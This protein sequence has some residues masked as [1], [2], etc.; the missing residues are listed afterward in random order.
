[1][2]AASL[3]TGPKVVMAPLPQPNWGGLHAV[4]EAV[5]PHVLDAGYEIRP[6]VPSSAQEIQKR[7]HRAGISAFTLEQT[8]LRRSI[9]PADHIRFLSGLVTDPRALGALAEDCGAEI[10]QA[11][12]LH[13]VQAPLAARRTGLALVWQIHSDFLPPVARRLLT[14]LATR[15]SDVI[16]VNGARVR[17][18]FPLIERL[19]ND[20]IIEFRAPI[21]SDRF[22]FTDAQRQA[23]R[24]RF[25]VGD[26]TIM[27]GTIGARSYQKGHE[28]MVALAKRLSSDDRIRSVI[29]GGEIAAQVSS[30][31]R[32]VVEPAQ[33]DGLVDSGKLAWVDAGARVLD[34]LPALDIFVL[35]SRAEGIP[36]AMLEAMASSLPVVASDVGSI[37]DVIKPDSN[38]F[39]IQPSPFDEDGFVTAV[40]RLAAD[41]A[42]RARLG[43]NGRETAQRDFSAVSVA[44]A[45]V[46]AY[47]TALAVRAAAKARS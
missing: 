41:P 46:A 4:I 27:I 33:R 32:T 29:I 18:A 7:F 31:N 14:P 47:E 11:A 2:T 1:M 6:V 12:G 3:R 5:S 16:M 44:K 20:R 42:L 17:A 22:V 38:G 45:H 40:Q 21:D 26:D 15:M 37:A 9:N 23:A 19:S 35:P 8:R 25:N 30:Y 13:N 24:Q 10:V 39:L 28:R 36:V 43:A 34:F